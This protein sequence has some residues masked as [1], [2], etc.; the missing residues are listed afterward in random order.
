MQVDTAMTCRITDNCDL[1]DICITRRNSQTLWVV[2]TGVRRLETG[3]LHWF[4]VV[5]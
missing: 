5:Q 1:T 3:E 2:S 4:R